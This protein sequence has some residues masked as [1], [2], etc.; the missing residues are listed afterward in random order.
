M[1][2]ECS[3]DILL[4]W[5]ANNELTLEL[6]SSQE[7]KHD[8]ISFRSPQVSRFQSS[9]PFTSSEIHF[10]TLHTKPSAASWRFTKLPPANEGVDLWRP[11]FE[12]KSPGFMDQ[13]NIFKN[14]IHF[15]TVFITCT[16]CFGN[17]TPA[18][19]WF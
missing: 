15:K 6:I 3:C 7:N 19:I 11:K 2:N 13:T 9:F 1:F 14:S 17:T 10:S 8:E 18:V 12:A 5:N 4:V 16:H